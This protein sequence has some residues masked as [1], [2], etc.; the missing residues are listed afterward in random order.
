MDARP[1]RQVNVTFHDWAEA[2][3]TAVTHL[4]PLLAEAEDRGC[5]TAWFFMR[6][7]PCW[8]IRYVPGCDQTQAH[9]QGRLDGLPLVAWR[10][11]RER[12]G[13]GSSHAAAL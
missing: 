12:F 7:T 1:W 3:H 6:K 5:I 2:E 10:P 13:R 4:A 11:N 8:R 9:L